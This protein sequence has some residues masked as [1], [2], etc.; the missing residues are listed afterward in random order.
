MSDVSGVEIDGERGVPDLLVDVVD[1]FTSAYEVDRFVIF[2]E[3]C[4]EAAGV[5]VAATYVVEG[6]ERPR[7]VAMSGET[8]TIGMSA[9]AQAELAAVALADT[10]EDG[11][12]AG[13]SG[14]SV[15]VSFAPDGTGLVVA[16]I[17]GES[18]YRNTEGVVRT[19][20][21]VSA[22]LL[23]RIG[24][25]L[26]SQVRRV[27][28]GRVLTEQLQ[29][30]LVSRVVIEQAKGV[31][32]ERHHISTTEAF[33]LLRRLARGAGRAMQDVAGDVVNAVPTDNSRER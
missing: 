6:P 15:I 9:L 26:H 30:A 27:D 2:N 31:L 11:Y 12:F 25:R 5:D 14:E 24:V 1:A 3:A 28:G 23:V 18:G 20:G 10:G 17:P 16:L 32:V 13:S 7:L 33:Q 22:Q 21:V 8:T 4:R 19:D 29:T